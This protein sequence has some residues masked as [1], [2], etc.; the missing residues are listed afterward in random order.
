[1]SIKKLNKLESGTGQCCYWDVAI[2]FQKFQFCS[3]A[4]DN[5]SMKNYF[6]DSAFPSLSG[7]S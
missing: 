4:L 7:K 3:L 2:F 1:M 6:S 5:V